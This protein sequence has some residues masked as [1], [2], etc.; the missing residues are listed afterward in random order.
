MPMVS[1]K[2]GMST[3]W[4]DCCSCGV[5]KTPN[6]KL[7]VGMVKTAASPSRWPRRHS[8]AP[9]RLQQQQ[10]GGYHADQPDGD[11]RELRFAEVFLPSHG[12]LPAPTRI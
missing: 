4:P 7:M 12:F 6:T 8:G 5:V 1:Q 9:G 11:Q 10:Q 2:N 3:D